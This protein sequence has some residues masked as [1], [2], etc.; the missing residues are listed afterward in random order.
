MQLFYDLG[1]FDF[2]L[3]QLYK[4]WKQ[5][6]LVAFNQKTQYIRTA[7]NISSLETDNGINIV[8]GNNKN[9]DISTYSFAT[10]SKQ[11]SGSHTQEVML[12]FEK[13]FNK[14]GLRCSRIKY[15][16]LNSNS[17]IRTHVDL[18]YNYRYHYAVRTNEHCTMNIDNE[19]YVLNKPGHLYKVLAN[20][21]HSVDNKG[22]EMRLFLSF[23]VLEL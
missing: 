11:F 2:N 20:R 22:Q 10:I 19:S 8:G 14:Q 21:P 7:V 12:E 6:T 3:D 13:M 17:H 4:E 15:A 1:Y 16:A 23:D 5:A 9:Y 18:L